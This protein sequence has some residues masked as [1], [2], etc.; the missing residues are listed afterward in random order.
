MKKRTLLAI[1]LAVCA[2]QI[3]VQFW[4]ILRWENVLRNGQ[5]YK[6]RTEPVDPYDAFR[7]RYIALGFEAARVP[8]P[9]EASDRDYPRWKKFCAVIEIGA[10]GFAHF[11]SVQERRP[12]TGDYVATGVQYIENEPWFEDRDITDHGKLAKEIF[13]SD[14]PI[15]LLARSDLNKQD[16]ETLDNYAKAPSPAPA[17]VRRIL[18]QMIQSLRY[19]DLTACAGHDA[20]DEEKAKFKPHSDRNFRRNFVMKEFPGCLAPP[21]PV[22]LLLN[23]P[24]D[25]FY[26][27]ETK[28]PDAERAY[29]QNSLRRNHQTYALIR[30]LNGY[31][32]IENVI[33]GDQP[34]ADFIKTHPD[35]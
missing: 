3:A 17:D 6:F 31:A 4:L 33:I 34:I 29:R 8:L 26:M 28:A 24:F 11:K 10:D 32:I 2:V 13:S 5:G 18:I 22:R 19:K 12:D 20:N 15:C 25:R 7:G 23:L 16:R 21:P 27:A 1:F 14:R 35:K 30:V 9:V